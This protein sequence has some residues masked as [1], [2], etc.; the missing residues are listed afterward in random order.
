M[1]QVRPPRGPSFS[2]AGRGPGYRNPATGKS[3]ST[4]WGDVRVRNYFFPDLCEPLMAVKRHI[5]QKQSP[6]EKVWLN[7]PS[8]MSYVQERTES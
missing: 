7:Y 8:S 1:H 6:K 3:R 5:C 2:Y 4:L